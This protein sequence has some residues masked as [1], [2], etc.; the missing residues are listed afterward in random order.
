MQRCL[1]KH[2]RFSWKYIL[3]KR[4]KKPMQPIQS[5]DK[6]MHFPLPSTWPPIDGKWIRASSDQGQQER[7][8]LLKIQVQVRQEL[9]QQWARELRLCKRSTS[10]VHWME[11]ESTMDFFMFFMTRPVLLKYREIV[12]LERFEHT[13]HWVVQIFTCNCRLSFFWPHW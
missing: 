3:K 11:K 7:R 9:L 2:C 12:I 1:Q 5:E 8:K 10:S 13:G 4:K 6:T